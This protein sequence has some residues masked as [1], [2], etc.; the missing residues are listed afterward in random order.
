MF[1]KLFLKIQKNIKKSL[2]DLEGKKQ[3]PESSAIIKNI[4][5]FIT[6]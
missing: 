6:I 4:F 2:N 5:K 1:I 3:S